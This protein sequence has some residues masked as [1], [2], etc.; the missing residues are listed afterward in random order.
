MTEQ[1]QIPAPK[2]EV[3]ANGVDVKKFRPASSREAAKATLE[4]PSGAFVVG[5][6]GSLREV[7]NHILLIRAFARHVKIDPSSFLLVVGDGPM[8]S[9]LESQARSL[10]IYEQVRF[11]GHRSAVWKY[12]QAMDVF[13]QPSSKEGSP[14]ALL[15]A[16][17]CGVP[18][19]A[20]RSS[21]CVELHDK[22]GLPLLVE[23]DDEHELAAR[24]A[25]LRANEHH[26]LE[27]SK[28]CR[29]VVSDQFSFE[30][31]VD[32]YERLYRSTL[33]VEHG[34]AARVTA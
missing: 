19:V 9:T 23:C 17:A 28:R 18:V 21:G 8:R 12:V 30:R 14:T 29:Q 34:A 1:W 25:E 13:V 4:L 15:E 27:L 26:R 6:V 33:E 7:K 24:L 2:I 31:M 32:S 22:T 20:A 16:M 5:T 3:I 11:A 10:G